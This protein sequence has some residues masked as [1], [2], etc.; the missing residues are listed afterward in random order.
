MEIN[1]TDKQQRVQIVMEVLKHQIQLPP[2]LEL[3]MKPFLGQYL[4]L[5]NLSDDDIDKMIQV[6]QDKLDYIKYGDEIENE[7]ESD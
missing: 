4:N 3:I 5:Q 1:L 7:T 2:S 6:I